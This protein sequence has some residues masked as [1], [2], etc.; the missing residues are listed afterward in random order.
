MVKAGAEVMIAYEKDAGQVPDSWRRNGVEWVPV[1]HSGPDFFRLPQQRE[2]ENAL[3]GADLMVLHSAWTPRNNRAGTIARHLG[4]PYV[5]EPRGAYD[6]HIVGRHPWMKRFWFAAFERDL[7]M[8]ARAVHIFFDPEREHLAR[9]GYS[10]QVI[11][12]P[13]GVDTPEEVRWDGGS[14]D[15][16]LWMGRFDPE[17]KGIDLILKAID[18]MPES[19]RPHVRLHG[20]RWRSGKEKVT[21]MVR[22]MRLNQWV[23]V[24]EQVRGAAKFQLMA[25]AAGFIY[26]SR[27]EGFGNS[28]AEAISVG[29]PA[30]VTPYPFGRYLACR[31]AAILAEPTP[32]GLAQGL[33]RLQEPQ[34]REIARRGTWIAHNEITWEAVAKSWL[35]QIQSL[36]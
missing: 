10:G 33:K 12:A 24:R 20:P 13:N 36:L 2:L 7:L 26:P 34:V 21:A 11:V 3:R 31:E 15:Y 29:V 16:V 17:H 9:L 6:P 18:L 25:Q 8:H 23:E 27:W 1:R 14:G 30:V 35:T 5:L 22:N 28:V 19:E 4:V 32:A